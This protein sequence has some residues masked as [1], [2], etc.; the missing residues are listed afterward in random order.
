M[1]RVAVL[2][3]DRLGVPALR[4]LLE[5]KLVVAIGSSDI[6]SEITVLLKHIATINSVPFRVFNKQEI[7]ADVKA[8]LATY[9]PDIVLVKTFPWK[10]PSSLL[11]IPKHGFVNF[12]YA[13]LPHYRGKNPLFWMIR[14]R[15]SEGG[16]SVHRMDENLDTGEVLLSKSIEIYPDTSFGM[17]ISQLAFAGAELTMPLLEGLEADTLKSVKQDSSQANWY[18]RPKP[19]DLFISWQTM[20]SWEVRALAKACNPWQKGAVVKFKG[21]TFGFT[22]VSLSFAPVANETAPGTIVELDETNGML[23]ACSDGKAIK[24]EVVYC[25]EGYFP[26]HKMSQFGLRKGYILD[27]N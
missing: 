1:M 23:V 26:G 21:W 16:V 19:D 4:H 17:L 2:C 15:V 11:K 9:N 13:P 10:I 25:E 7:E 5:N 14:N 22:D 24:A 6:S 12:H 20:N 8:W 3:N 27:Y 18:D